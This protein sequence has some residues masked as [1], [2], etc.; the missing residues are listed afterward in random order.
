M[1]K[2]TNLFVDPTGLIE[3]NRDI[4]FL[5]STGKEWM[6]NYLKIYYFDG[7]LHQVFRKERDYDLTFINPA[8]KEKNLNDINKY[9]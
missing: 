5:E 7:P 8:M 1:S 2:R 3:L 4:F 6:K 9:E